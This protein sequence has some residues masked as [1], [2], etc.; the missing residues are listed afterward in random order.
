MVKAE[1]G[2][3][4]MR[5]M[6][7]GGL[8]TADISSRGTDIYRLEISYN[9]RKTSGHSWGIV[10]RP[11]PQHFKLALPRH[12]PHPDKSLNSSRSYNI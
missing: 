3:L 1:E 12:C 9:S 8:S 11:D 4:C 5:V 6:P 7:Q 10:E 2:L